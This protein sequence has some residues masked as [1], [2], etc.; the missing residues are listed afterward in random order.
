MRE[1]G[2][3]A[4]SVGGPQWRELSALYQRAPDECAAAVEAALSSVLLST[5]HSNFGSAAVIKVLSAAG[6]S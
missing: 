4:A 2:Y 5:D 1:A 6:Y 3:A